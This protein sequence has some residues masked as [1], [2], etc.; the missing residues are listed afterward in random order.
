MEILSSL[1]TVERAIPDSVLAGLATREYTLHGGVVRNA[2]GQIVRHLVPAASKSLDPFGLLAV[3]GQFVNTWQL[4]NLTKMTEQV[5]AIS[6]TTMAL[7]G[8]NLAVSAVGFSM[9]YKSLRDMDAR[10]KTMDAKLDWIKTFLDSER[11]SVLLHAADELAALPGDPEHRKQILHASR[12]SVGTVAMH[13]LQH[14]DESASIAEAM[15][16]QHYYCMGFL[17]KARCSAELGMYENSVKEIEVGYENWRERSRNLANTAILKDDPDRFLEQEYLDSVPTTK[18]VS[19]MEFATDDELGFEWIDKLRHMA[20]ERSACMI[21]MGG[22]DRPR[23]H[24][25]QPHRPHPT[26]TQPALIQ[27]ALTQLA[28]IQPARIQPTD[29]PL[30]LPEPARP[31]PHRHQPAAPQPN[32]HQPNQHQPNQ[33]QPTRCQPNHHQPNQDQP[34]RPRLNRQPL[35]PPEPAPPQAHRHQP[36]APQPSRDLPLRPRPTGSEPSVPR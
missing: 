7:S 35:N 10:L 11:R 16:Y 13:Y 18:L 3:P 36:A 8:L 6:Q 27:L 1:F 26:W 28:R 15:A 2:G 31:Q 23:L 5:L 17:L 9:L 25:P 29:S 34:I 33:H 20:A 30:N 32:Q 19:W 14:W 4:H 21:A 12:D 24:R 22:P